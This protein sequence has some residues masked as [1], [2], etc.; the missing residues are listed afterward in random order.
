LAGPRQHQSTLCGYGDQ[1]IDELSIDN[2]NFKA[3]LAFRF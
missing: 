2:N 3:A 1:D